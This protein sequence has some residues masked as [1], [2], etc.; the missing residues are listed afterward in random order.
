MTLL[1]VIFPG[2]RDDPHLFGPAW[3]WVL[4][5]SCYLE[6]IKNSK[7]QQLLIPGA[8]GGTG[9]SDDFQP[10]SPSSPSVVRH[11]VKVAC[12]RQ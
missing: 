11:I 4:Y 1:Q 2:P 10:H 7:E 6:H 5:H 3:L 12:R 9:L 8:S